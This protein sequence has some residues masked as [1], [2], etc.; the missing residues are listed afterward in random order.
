MDFSANNNQSAEE[1]ISY[2]LGG[3]KDA[4]DGFYRKL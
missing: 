4:N 3:S 1:K 2:T